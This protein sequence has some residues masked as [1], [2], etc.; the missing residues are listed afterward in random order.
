MDDRL[1]PRHFRS[2]RELCS[3]SPLPSG[4]LQA[5]HMTAPD[6]SPLSPKIAFAK[7]VADTRDPSLGAGLAGE[8]KC[9]L[10][11]PATGG[12]E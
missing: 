3:R 12:R 1:P 5:G 2:A 10:I 8:Y 6:Q 4:V 11:A 7:P 9:F